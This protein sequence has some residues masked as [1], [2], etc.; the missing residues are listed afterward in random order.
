MKDERNS[1]INSILESADGVVRATAPDFFY[2]RLKARM[3]REMQ[4][5][6]RANWILRPAFALIILGLLLSVN[7]YLIFNRS[8]QAAQPE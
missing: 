3:E 1:R 6:I 4:E 5:P 8:Q 2:T 7:S